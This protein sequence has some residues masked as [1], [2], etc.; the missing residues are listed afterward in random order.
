MKKYILALLTSLLL[1]TPVAALT[2]T[3]V[4]SNLIY[5][6]WT[7]PIATQLDGSLYFSG[8]TSGGSERTFRKTGSTITKSILQTLPEADD[9]NAPSMLRE[10][11]KDA[12]LFYTRHNRSNIV[13]YWRAPEGTIDFEDKGNLTFPYRVTYSQVLSEGNR[14]ILLTRS[15]DCRWY[16]RVND[17][18]GA[19]GYWDTPKLVIDACGEIDGKLYVLTSPSANQPIVAAPHPTDTSW[20]NVAYGEVD[21]ASGQI[22]SSE[23]VIGDIDA[24]DPI[25]KD[26]LD[27][28]NPNQTSDQHTRL[29]DVG[30]MYGVPTI[31]YAKWGSNFD[32]RYYIAFYNGTG[33]DRYYLGL[34]AGVPFDGAN[35]AKKYVAGAAIMHGTN[36]LVVAAE[37]GGTS[38]IRQYPLTGVNPATL[39]EPT[40]IA[41]DATY[42][43][44]L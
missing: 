34:T 27:E 44:F 39:G 6:W 29:L 36:N 21:V 26:Q 10:T 17:N 35:T 41:T 24:G 2:T 18:Y 43:L 9:H 23:G 22:T 7:H 13:N 33:F 20:S 8:V 28:V 42:R 12:L 3:Q 1:A 14:I 19:S 37:S 30:E 5:S 11:G 25:D 38:T 4:S 31:V 16:A 40:T 32:P 15:G